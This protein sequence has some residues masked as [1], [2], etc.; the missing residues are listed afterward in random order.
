MGGQ[1]A[2]LWFVIS[3]PL[4]L[5]DSQRKRAPRTAASRDSSPRVGAGQVEIGAAGAFPFAFSE[6]RVSV[7]HIPRAMALHC[8]WRGCAAPGPFSDDKSLFE[9]L[10]SAHNVGKPRFR[11]RWAGCARESE[12]RGETDGSMHLIS[13]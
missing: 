13:E 2:L 10:E 4:L 6:S 8:L 5:D 9:H 11:C 3:M 1:S 7:C 12:L